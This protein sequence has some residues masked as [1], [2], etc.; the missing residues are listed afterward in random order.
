MAAPK[1]DNVKAAI[2]DAAERL[3]SRQPEVSLA[4]IAAEAGISKGTL[5]YH[6]RSKTEIY[7]DIGERYWTQLSNDLLKWVDDK[8]KVTTPAR[9]VRYTMQR[10]VFDKSGPLRLHLFVD[11]ISQDRRD[12]GVRE[13]LIGQYI[14]FKNILK[15]RILQRIPGADGERVAWMLLTMV[16]GLMVQHSL[17]NTQLDIDAYIEWLAGL[18]PGASES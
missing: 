18:F 15:T 6:Y 10:G 2:L 8:D 9:L 12:N 7:L 14:H 17:N 13:A 4:Q 1:N 3:L 16:D 5:F 11:A